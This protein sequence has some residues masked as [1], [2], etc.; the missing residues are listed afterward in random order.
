MYKSFLQRTP[1]IKKKHSVYTQKNLQK[2]TY[3][4]SIYKYYYC[5]NKY[6]LRIES[7]STTDRAYTVS[8][9]G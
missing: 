6:L 3:T 5:F 2:K 4:D 1:D 7:I 8:L 9:H